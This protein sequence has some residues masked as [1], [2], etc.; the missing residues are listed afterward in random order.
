MNTI[1]PLSKRGVGLPAEM[2]V[3]A[4]VCQYKNTIH[5][6]KFDQLNNQALF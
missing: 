1:R 4:G 2:P 6:F 3:Q 5:F